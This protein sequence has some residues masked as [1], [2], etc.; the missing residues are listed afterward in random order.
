M[1]TM[2]YALNIGILDTVLCIVPSLNLM[3]CYSIFY[4]C[5]INA[6][7][8]LANVRRYVRYMLSAVRLLSVCCL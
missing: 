8:F 7:S 2:L 6:N 3:T 1:D 5:L 4:F